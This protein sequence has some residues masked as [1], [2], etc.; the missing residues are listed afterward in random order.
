MKPLKRKLTGKKGETLVESLLSVLLIALSLCMF[1]NLLTLSGRIL[2][3]GKKQEDRFRK[4][5]S[6]LE[7]MEEDQSQEELVKSDSGEVRISIK[8]ENGDTIFRGQVPVR[9]YY[10]HSMTAY[11][12]EE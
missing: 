2:S 8:S 11:E 9:V 6:L 5:M 1:F 7:A 3:R 4:T 10:S 12:K